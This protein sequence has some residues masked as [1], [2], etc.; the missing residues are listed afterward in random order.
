MD[1]IFFLFPKFDVGAV[2]YGIWLAHTLENE[3]LNMV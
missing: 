2:K 1:K 3:Q